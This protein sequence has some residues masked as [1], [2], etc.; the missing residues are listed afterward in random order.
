[1]N[2]DTDKV[3][4]RCRVRAKFHYTDTD[5]D[6]FAAKRT[7]T[8]PTEFRRKKVR[9]RVRVVEFSYYGVRGLP[10]AAIKVSRSSSTFE[11]PGR[12]RAQRAR[13]RRDCLYGRSV[14]RRPNKTNRGGVGARRARRRT[15]R[16]TET[17]RAIS[18]PSVT[19]D[20]IG[21]YAELVA[22]SPARFDGAGIGTSPVRRRCL[23]KCKTFA[24]LDQTPI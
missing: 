18:V 21:F 15:A 14:G 1:M 2:T 20:G 10:S 11:A 8:D 4:A 5:T 23:K 22:A 17:R 7:R 19:L 3:R 16:P 9:V 13:R 12:R 24:P 6:F